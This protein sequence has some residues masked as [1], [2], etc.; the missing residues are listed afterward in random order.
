[1]LSA[2]ADSLGDRRLL[3]GAV[4]LAHIEPEFTESAFATPTR[5]QDPST[6]ML[7]SMGSVTGAPPRPAGMFHSR[8]RSG[9][10]TESGKGTAKMLRVEARKGYAKRRWEIRRWAQRDTEDARFANENSP[11]TGLLG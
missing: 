1:M 4:L 3:L 10:N 7:F 5:R 2:Y 9:Y 6:L 11:A 8:K